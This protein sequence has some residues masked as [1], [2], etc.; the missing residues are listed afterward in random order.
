LGTGRQWYPWIDIDD[1]ICSL[2][3][4]IDK[5]DANGSFNLTAPNP[6]TNSDFSRGL[7]RV[8]HPPSW[9]PV[10]PFVLQTALGEISDLIL[11]GQRAISEKLNQAGFTFTF[12]EA[13]AALDDPLSPK[14]FSLTVQRA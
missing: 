10:P 6:L 4:L 14:P 7:E 12:T 11:T 2:R 9:F 13:E 3:F 5:G 8:M 1:V